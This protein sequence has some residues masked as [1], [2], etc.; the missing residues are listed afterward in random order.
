MRNAKM[1]VLESIE[2]ERTHLDSA[3]VYPSRDFPNLATAPA[4]RNGRRLCRVWS[5]CRSATVASVVMNHLVPW[6]V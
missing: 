2:D 4:Q 3:S 1:V 5:L 6:V